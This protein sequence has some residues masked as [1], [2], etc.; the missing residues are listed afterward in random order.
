MVQSVQTSN[1]LGN[2]ALDGVQAGAD[3]SHDRVLQVLVPELALV[4]V[5]DLDRAGLFTAGLGVHL[6]LDVLDLLHADE[7]VHQSGHGLVL[8]PVGLELWVG[9][10]ESVNRPEQV[11]VETHIGRLFLEDGHC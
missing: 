9:L 8:D 10:A 11:R 5:R 2:N 7:K 1:P 6:L 3:L 4:K